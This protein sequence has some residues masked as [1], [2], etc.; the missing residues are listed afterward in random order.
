MGL[1]LISILAFGPMVFAADEPAPPASPTEGLKSETELGLVLTSGNS[2][3]S[4]TN[5]KQGTSYEWSGNTLRLQARFLRTSTRGTESAK[6][7]GLGLRYERAL[8][9]ALSIYVG[10]ALES[11]TYAGYLQKH[12]SDVG[13]KYFF[14]K[15]EETVASAELGYRY[16][17]ENTVLGTQNKSHYLRAYLEAL[18][19]WNRWV[20]M[21]ASLEILPN[22]TYAADYQVNGEI[23]LAAIISSLFSLKTSYAIRYDHVPAAGAP[24]T[25]DTTLTTALVVRI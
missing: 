5:I 23:S 9:D 8:T 21:K 19:N 13:G 16:T 4:T 10:Q 12:N 2:K 25:T 17:I 24:E 7:Y 15:S 14:M 6:N 3:T 20:S 18:R 11:D 1:A 22:L